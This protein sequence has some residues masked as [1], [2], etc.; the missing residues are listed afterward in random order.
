MSSY[1]IYYGEYTLKYWI[2]MILNKEIILPPYQRYFVWS[3]EKVEKLIASLQENQYIP[4]VVIGS[5]KDNEVEHNYVLDGQ[6]RLSAILLAWLGCFPK[7][8]GFA[9]NI[10]VFGTYNDDK[11]YN[12]D[13]DE[14]ENIQAWKFTVIQDLIHN[15][16]IKKDDIKEKLINS[17]QYQTISNKILRDI[18]QDFFESKRLGFSYVRPKDISDSKAQKRYFSTMFR[19]INISAVDL[20]PVE[21]RS[22]L[23]WLDEGIQPFLQPDEK[24]VL[25]KIKIDTYDMDFARY[26]ALLSEYKKQGETKNIAK[27]FV[28]RKGK[29]IEQYIEEYIYYLVDKKEQ[30][31]FY[32]F[33][34]AFNYS[35]EIK[36]LN[37]VY[38]K[39]NFPSKYISIIDADYYLFG[40]LYFLIFKN[41]DHTSIVNNRNN[42]TD[43]L[44][45]TIF[46]SKKNKN[47]AKTEANPNFWTDLKL[48]GLSSVFYRTQ[49][50]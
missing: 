32:I 17:N 11:E 14:Q 27:G 28:G 49:A 23:Y 19:N 45:K 25:G 8:K 2:N 9:E 47:H 22:S 40:L 29:T 30:N 43:M 5:Y 7:G 6:Q 18:N 50:I 12:D 36:K 34:A 13:G 15:G 31:K 16:K 41:I 42:I 24:S 21:S 4:P 48:Y 26:I 20:T 39:L 37:I 3:Q 44:E 33:G 38:E 1:N 35:E 10:K 46:E